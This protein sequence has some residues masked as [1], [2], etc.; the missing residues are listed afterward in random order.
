MRH[1]A[2]RTLAP[3]RPSV[4]VAVA[5]AV[6][7]GTWVMAGHTAP[8]AGQATEPRTARP[9]P[10]GAEAW[11]LFGE[12]LVP[13]TPS[14]E[15]LANLSAQLDEAR[16]ALARAPNDPDAL[17]WVGR[18]LAY[19]GRYREA[20]ATFT[21]GVARHPNDPRMLRHRGHRYLTVREFDLAKAD[22][23]G[24]AILVDG[25]ADEIEP[26]G[27]PNARNTPTSTLQSNIWYHL[28]L[29]R[30]VSGDFAAAAEAYRACLTVSKNPDMQVATTYW[31]YLTLRRLG[32]DEEATRLLAPIAADMDIIENHAYHRLLL[33]YK[34]ASGVDA[35]LDGTAGL[36]RATTAYGVGGWH[37][38]SGRKDD[39]A[40]AWRV[41]REAGSW[42][43]FGA[44][45]AE[46]DLFRVGRE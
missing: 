19:L 14:P 3:A 21:D 38:V 36:D 42:A 28:G 24:A 20:I 29:A 15:A 13:P 40:R 2:H 35:L 32:H 31:A 22:L 5:I 17:I 30:Y 43:S 12:P 46:A 9:L 44:I 1:D 6:A 41:A 45:A 18:R 11:S 8:E 39:A 25:R 7:G 37:F 27:Q 26:D 10:D 33:A 4:L 34:S 16:A 23:A